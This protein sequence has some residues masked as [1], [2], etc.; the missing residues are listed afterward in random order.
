MTG[1]PLK[2]L[3]SFWYH[4]DR[5]LH[6]DMATYFPHGRPQTFADSG[7]FSAWSQGSY[8]SVRSYGNWLERYQEY[9]TAYA[10][11]DIKESVDQTR[12]NQ[13][14]LEDRGLH[15]L[16]VYH[17]GEEESVLK[18]YLS[19]YP[20]VALG[21]IA[22][23]GKSGELVCRWLSRCFAL[24]RVTGSVYHG[25]GM[26]N[27]LYLQRFPFY[28]ADSSS[29]GSGFRFGA[30]PLY[31]QRTGKM[32]LISLGKPKENLKVLP[33]LTSYGLSPLLYADRSRNDRAANALLGALSYQRLEYD[34]Q[35]AHGP[36]EPPSGQ[37]GPGLHLYLAD[38]AMGKNPF[39]NFN[40]IMEGMARYH[41]IMTGT[42]LAGPRA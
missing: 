31:D 34:L 40:R 13:R 8:L 38:I 19:R 29:W 7:G 37:P 26:T 27:T 36:V 39:A 24:A 1:I 35:R 3:I 5:D 15:P 12:K 42:A 9:F 41:P 32:R 14:Y 23:G 20:Y 11:L 22:G 30:V 18:G 16:P 6:Q 25:F 21:G 17:S 2:I 4:R 33:V 28:S 10:N